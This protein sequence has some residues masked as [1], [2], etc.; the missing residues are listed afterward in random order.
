MMRE[1]A[2]K[3]P[4]DVVWRGV[5]TVSVLVFLFA[6]PRTPPRTTIER[7]S[8]GFPLHPFRWSTFFANLSDLGYRIVTLTPG[9][10]LSG[11]S[12]RTL[13]PSHL[14]PSVTLLSI[15]LGFAM[16]LGVPKGVYDGIRNPAPTTGSTLS[17]LIEWIVNSI[18]DFFLIFALELFGFFLLRKGI[19]V[20]FVGSKTFWSGTMVPA[21]ILSL[22][23]MMYLARAVKVSVAA[24]LGQ[25]YVQT[26]YS[27]GLS[28]RLVLRHHILP[29]CLPT[30]AR[31]MAPMLG[32][33][34]SGLV[35][36]EYLFDRTGIGSGL[37]FAMGH[38]GVSPIYGTPLG[39]PPLAQGHPFDVN[40]CVSLMIAAVIVFA[41]F[42]VG[43]RFILLV[44]GY[45]GI[46]GTYASKLEENPSG[47]RWSLQLVV[48]TLM[49]TI[50]IG[51]AFLKRHL[52]I[53]TPNH[54]DVL[55]FQGNSMSTP[56][57]P[58]SVRHWLGTDA[59]GRDLLSRCI[60]GIAPTL[61]YVLI[62]DLV[63]VGAGA[64]LAVLSASFNL[65]CMRF[66]VDTWNSVTSVIPGIIFAL[67]ILEI[68]AVYWAGVQLGPGHIVWGPIHQIIF[69]AVL[70]II[71]GGR[72]AGQLQGTL[73]TEHKRSYMEAAMVSGNSNW[74]RF[75]LYDLRPLRDSAVEQSIVTFT[76]ILLI[77]ATLGFF[78]DVL[79]P[80]WL[81]VNFG[82]W[83]F[84]G[85][86]LDWGSLFAQNA[87]DFLTAPWV[88]FPPSLFV[89]W[90][91]IAVNLIHIGVHRILNTSQRSKVQFR[92]RRLRGVTRIGE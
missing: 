63:A 87:R 48:G 88:M 11:Q 16:V 47:R 29:N 78:E 38:D 62:T 91:A 51:L 24:E 75:L 43:L 22:S 49:V 4:W 57:F 52:G 79:Q 73:D 2:N 69:V 17:G 45:K 15:A 55:H 35:L 40:W 1:P 85:T 64:M 50:L 90:T 61:S 82:N 76:R 33:L 89:A 67:L 58:P 44:L 37:F 54:M 70:S 6:Y 18:P 10:T 56:P 12:I 83:E 66:I 21:F 14:W 59:S 8:S 86:S 27:K 46:A 81:K 92:I 23:P 77:I 26:A 20:Y 3:S 32:V 7:W 31:S 74:T 19:H 9:N 13:L 53:P 42:W 28:K 30:I 72:V 65:R 34:F 5:I 71:E 84:T 25:P 68:P 80:D 39:N 60:Y 41:V 36:V